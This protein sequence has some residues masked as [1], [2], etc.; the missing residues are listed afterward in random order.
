MEKLSIK[1]VHD[2]QA[3]VEDDT[4]SSVIGCMSVFRGQSDATWPLIPSIVRKPKFDYRIS[5]AKDLSSP[6]DYSAERRLI[7]LFRELAVSFLPEWTFSG[8]TQEVLWKHLLLSQH[9][10]VPTR[11]LDWSTNPLVALFFAVYG[12]AK[13][14]TQACEH[15]ADLCNDRRIHHSAVYVLRSRQSFSISSLAANN[16]KAPL[17]IHKTDP[18]IIQP[19]LIDKRFIAQSSVFAISRCPE[20]SLLPDATILID[21]DSRDRILQELDGYS[22]NVRTLF[23]DLEHLG[24]YLDWSVPR[25]FPPSCRF[26]ESQA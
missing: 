15:A 24:E 25:W 2:F 7:T 9:Y 6:D 26:P 16:P 8:T 5:L 4:R 23:P 3:I 12:E 21:A 11:L 18:G 19:P 1:S 20:E 14:C 22:I 13:R 10:R 17:Y